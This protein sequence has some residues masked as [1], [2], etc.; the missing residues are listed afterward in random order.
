[1]VKKR[2]I[3]NSKTLDTLASIR[4][5]I[6]TRRVFKGEVLSITIRTHRNYKL[7]MR[8][9]DED[10]E[11]VRYYN[12]VATPDEVKVVETGRLYTWSK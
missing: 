4:K 6:A 11:I 3:L 7:L 2:I 9:R 10:T 12:I 5:A 8:E 1:M